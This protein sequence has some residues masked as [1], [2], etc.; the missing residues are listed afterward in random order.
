MRHDTIPVCRSVFFSIPP[1]VN[2][3]VSA[4]GRKVPRIA[5]AAPS[6]TNPKPS[7]LIAVAVV[8]ADVGGGAL[9][10]CV[11]LL[12]AQS[13][14]AEELVGGSLVRSKT[15]TTLGSFFWRP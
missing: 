9:L 4:H 15:P 3:V 10:L 8:A 2:A 6:S 12:L 7:G 1:K 13:D 5:I 14:F 11:G